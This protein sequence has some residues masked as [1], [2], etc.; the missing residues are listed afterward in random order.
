[1]IVDS[2]EDMLDVLDKFSE[3]EFIIVDNVIQ[4]NK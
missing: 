2:E 3:M 1:M 4:P